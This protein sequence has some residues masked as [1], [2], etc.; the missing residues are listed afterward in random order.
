MVGLGQDTLGFL[1]TPI[2][3]L[4]IL[5]LTFEYLQQQLGLITDGIQVNIQKPQFCNKNNQPFL[6]SVYNVS[7]QL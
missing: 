6:A 7:C 4:S 3:S 2:T 5:S 1:K